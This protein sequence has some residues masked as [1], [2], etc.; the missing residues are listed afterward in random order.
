MSGSSVTDSGQTDSGRTD[1]GRPTGEVMVVGGAGFIGSHLVDR[2]MSTISPAE[3]VWVDVVDDLSTGSL[4]NLAEARA[5]A[6]AVSGSLRIH[7]LNAGGAEAASLI[8]MRRPSVIY[9]CASLPHSDASPSEITRSLELLVQ[10]MEAAR[11][12]E[13]T[14]VVMVIP[15]SVLYGTPSTRSLPVKERE[16]EPRGVRGVIARAMVDLLEVYRN[17]YAIEFTVLA[18]ASV[19]G[20]RQRHGVVAALRTARDAAEPPVLRGDGRETRDFV[21]VDD[22]VDA[23]VRAGK[24]GSGLVINIGTGVQTS[25]DDLWKL[26]AGEARPVIHDPTLG[27][28][29]SRFA[30][31]TVRARIHLGWSA[32]TPLADGLALLDA[33]LAPDR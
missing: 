13:V 5:M 8:A 20:P 11:R 4:A 32:W 6:T 21:H 29:L 30:L 22:V 18:T 24:R 17:R 26:I 19:Y 3:P 31:S 23:L 7:H 16:I 2:L 14:K 15:A 27:S 10:V 25:L 12:S 28:D 9:L 33:Q 1:S